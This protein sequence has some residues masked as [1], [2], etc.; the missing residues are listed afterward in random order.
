MLREAW[1]DIIF[2]TVYRSAP[3]YEEDQPEFLNAAASFESDD[4]PTGIQEVLQSIEKTLKKEI[5]Y[6]NGPRTIDLDLLLYDNLV[7][8][9]E[10]LTVPHPRM[11]ERLFVLAPLADI[12]DENYIHPVSKKTIAEMREEIGAE[13]CEMVDV[14]L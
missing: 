3:K 1:P 11:A 4:D 12:I 8:E 10:Q 9:S 5:P 13:G 14:V 6:P 2:S 7:L